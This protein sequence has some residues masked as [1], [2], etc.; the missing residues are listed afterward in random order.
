MIAGRHPEADVRFIGALGD[1]GQALVDAASAAAL[2]VVG[3]RGRG[4]FRSLLLGSVSSHSAH[5]AVCPTL[6]V[7]HVHPTG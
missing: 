4:G 3:N 7:P 2:L 1:P 5:R 6:V